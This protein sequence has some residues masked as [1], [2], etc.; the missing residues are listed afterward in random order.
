MPKDVCL[1][2]DLVEEKGICAVLAL[3]LGVD[4]GV[5]LVLVGRGIGES[6]DP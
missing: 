3:A 5:G 4:L 1:R 6:S 2:F